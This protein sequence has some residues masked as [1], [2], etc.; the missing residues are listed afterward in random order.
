M[1]ATE[2]HVLDDR[3]WSK[4]RKNPT[5]GCWEWNSSKNNRGYGMFSCRGLGFRNKKLAHR[6]SY[7][8]HNGPIDAGKH[9]LH[10][11]DNPS[12]VNPD[13]LSCGSRSDNMRDCSN[14]FRSGNQ[15]VTDDIRASIFSEYIAGAP[16]DEIAKRHGV[17]PA[18]VSDYI[19]GRS[20]GWAITGDE[21]KRLLAAKRIRPGA[22]ISVDDV[23]EIKRLLSEGMA[24]KD[25]AA[26]F[27]VHKATVSDIKTG[28][29]WAAIT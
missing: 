22:K 8:F 2:K 28:K 10:A 29:C 25:I 12:C 24:G 5:N 17:S 11:C 3:F 13:H 19:S 15:I 27:G 20:K 1:N 16:R 9:I 23:R 7:E 4:V 18:T 6:L 26:A 14:K 21:G